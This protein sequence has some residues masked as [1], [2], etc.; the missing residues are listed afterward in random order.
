MGILDG[1]TINVLIAKVGLHG[2][3]ILECIRVILALIAES[4]VDKIRQEDIVADLIRDSGLML[5][6][7]E[8]YSIYLRRKACV[9]TKQ[10]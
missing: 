8:Y 6:E 7:S 9:K 5:R 1:L 2:M 10:I 3:I 4:Q